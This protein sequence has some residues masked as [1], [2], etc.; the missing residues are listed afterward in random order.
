LPISLYLPST[1]AGSPEPRP[2]EYGLKTT[3]RTLQPVVFGLEC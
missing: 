3:R 1:F 2:E